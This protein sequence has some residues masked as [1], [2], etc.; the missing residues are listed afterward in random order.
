MTSTNTRSASGI[1]TTNGTETPDN[2]TRNRATTNT[3]RRSSAIRWVRGNREKIVTGRTTYQSVFAGFQKFQS[4]DINSVRA[5]ANCAALRF[6]QSHEDAFVVEGVRCRERRLEDV[7][8]RKSCSVQSGGH[9]NFL[10]LKMASIGHCSKGFPI[11][12]TSRWS[13][14]PHHHR[15]AKVRE[16]R[17]V[18]WK[19]LANAAA[20]DTAVV[21]IAPSSAARSSFC[22]T[23]PACLADPLLPVARAIGPQ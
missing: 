20:P 14:K 1:R 2:W 8:T 4:A 15:H 5:L 17:I 19:N 6:L 7:P 13:T 23:H 18:K 11:P 10:K 12:S 16:E 9:S 21:D 3:A 22:A